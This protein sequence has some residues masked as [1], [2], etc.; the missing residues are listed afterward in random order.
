MAEQK[1]VPDQPP[2]YWTK[3]PGT[4]EMQ[5]PV[6]PQMQPMYIVD[7]ETNTSPLPYRP[8]GSKVEKVYRRY[9][10]GSIAGILLWIVL[11]LVCIF[12]P[13]GVLIASGKLGPRSSD[14]LAVV[15]TY[16]PTS[17]M[18]PTPTPTVTTTISASKESSTGV[19]TDTVTSLITSVAVSTVTY[20][21]PSVS[22]SVTTDLD[23]TTVSQ[24][25]PSVVTS[26]VTS[27][28]TNSAEPTPTLTSLG[29]S[30]APST[31]TV[32]TTVIASSTL[33]TASFVTV[34][35]STSVDPAS[36]LN[37]PSLAL[38]TI[39]VGS[40]VII[41]GPVVSPTFQLSAPVRPTA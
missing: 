20:T 9:C 41:L 23:T 33:V 13:L 32:Y 24:T 35:P 7:P 36:H 27:V 34:T 17:S 8:Y 12:V 18:V 3:T 28:L 11:L 39:T 19:A 25:P 31:H 29:K 38:D 14:K 10:C 6:Q 4:F 1:F 37:R 2:R 22:V 21:P 5:P 26:M 40:S 15:S 16:N 30:E